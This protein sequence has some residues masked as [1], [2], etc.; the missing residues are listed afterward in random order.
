MLCDVLFFVLLG[1]CLIVFGAFVAHKALAEEYAEKDAALLER[2]RAAK[3]KGDD[4]EELRSKLVNWQAE[5]IQRLQRQEEGRNAEYERKLTALYAAETMLARGQPPDT[6]PQGVSQYIRESLR[7]GVLVGE[8]LRVMYLLSTD[9]F[10]IFRWEVDWPVTEDPMVR[11]RRDEDVVRTDWGRSGDHK[12]QLP[13]G[14]YLYEFSIENPRA[15][16]RVA[17]R[18]LLVEIVVPEP[19][20]WDTPAPGGALKKELPSQRARTVLR[21]KVGTFL[22][23]E[24]AAAKLRREVEKVLRDQ[25]VSEDDF[26][27]RMSRLDARIAEIRDEIGV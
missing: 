18:P 1:L 9:G 11:I 23:T 2:E 15:Q 6:S 24:K 19:A 12:D 16:N 21:E 25:A 10:L 8:H 4:A 7:Q 22:A 13:P 26:D 14:D 27:D 17:G 20:V 5:W 3:K